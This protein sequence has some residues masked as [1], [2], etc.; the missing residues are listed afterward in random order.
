MLSEL[1]TSTLQKAL[2]GRLD[3]MCPELAPGICELY[4]SIR[5]A[6]DRVLLRRFTEVC[7]RVLPALV[8]NPAYFPAL[9]QCGLTP[10]DLRSVGASQFALLD[11]ILNLVDYPLDGSDKL[12][13]LEYVLAGD[14]LWR[15][16]FQK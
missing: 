13:L 9:V 12:A 3:G 14:Q 6:K 4:E 2:S 11:G 7:N 1:P 15:R 8:L 16:G 5:K 10:V